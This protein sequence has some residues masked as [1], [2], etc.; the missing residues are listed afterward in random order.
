MIIEQTLKVKYL[1]NPDPNS[2]D[3]SFYVIIK[4]GLLE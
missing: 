2:T 4:S 3:E 1:F